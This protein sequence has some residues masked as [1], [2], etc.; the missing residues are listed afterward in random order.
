MV[1]IH[2]ELR[3][4]KKTKF[5]VVAVA[6]L[7][8]VAASGSVSA[9]EIVEGACNVS[10]VTNGGTNATSCFGVFDDANFNQADIDELYGVGY[11]LLGKSDSAGS[12]V[13]VS[14]NTWSAPALSGYSSFIVGLKQATSWATYYFS[15]V[16]TTGGTWSTSGWTFIG[17]PA[18]GLSHLSV[19]VKGTAVPEPG[20]LALI[21]M[22][23]L[24][25]AASARR[26]LRR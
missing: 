15:P 23:L 4:V 24:G 11:S 6:A 8:A 1:A 10:D 14:G 17:E 3:I 12:G 16:N 2:Q 9:I 25:L 18:G 20:T 22:G 5:G 7:M 13:T 26:K 21:G 19:Y